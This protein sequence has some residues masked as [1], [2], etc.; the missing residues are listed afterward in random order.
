[1]QGKWTGRCLL[2]GEEKEKWKGV[3]IL[4]QKPSKMPA[5]IRTA[6]SWTLKLIVNCDIIC[7]H[8][9]FSS[10]VLAT[11]FSKSGTKVRHKLHKFCAIPVTSMYG[12]LKHSTNDVQVTLFLW[13]VCDP[14]FV[15]QASVQRC[16]MYWGTVVKSLHCYHLQRVIIRSWVTVGLWNEQDLR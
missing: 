6:H 10:K 13:L 9:P 16:D 12:W 8:D 3:S 5:S 7:S 4:L 2:S 15:F 1:M 14:I 11:L